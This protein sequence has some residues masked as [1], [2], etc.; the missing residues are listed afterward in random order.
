MGSRGRSSFKKLIL[1][2]SASGIMTYAHCPVM[3]VK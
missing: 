1:W 3:I 2:S